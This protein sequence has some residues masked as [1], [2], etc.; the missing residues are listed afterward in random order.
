ML[1][2]LRTFA[3][4]FAPKNK[5]SIP[6]PSS[7]P[8]S[9]PSPSSKPD[10][11]PNINEYIKEWLAIENIATKRFGQK[12]LVNYPNDA[13]DPCEETVIDE[14]DDNKRYT[15]RKYVSNSTN[16]N[17]C[18]S[19]DRIKKFQAP[20]TIVGRYS[21]NSKTQYSI[22]FEMKE[23]VLFN[24]CF[25]IKGRTFPMYYHVMLSEETNNVYILFP[26]GGIFEKDEFNKNTELKE[27]LQE[28]VD[29]ILEQEMYKMKKII[30]CG[31]S[32][33]CVLAL[34]TGMIMQ[35]Q[36]KDFFDNNVIIIGSAPFKYANDESFT[37]LKNVMVFV[38]A[39]SRKGGNGWDLD[40]FVNQG[41]CEFNY[42]PITYVSNS[43]PEGDF[44][45]TIIN[46]SEGGYD[47][48]KFMT[49][50]GSFYHRWENYQHVL[51][52]IYVEPN[53][54]GHG[55]GK[56]NKTRRRQRRNK[57][58]NTKKNNTQY[59]KNTQYKNNKK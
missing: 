7:S 2:S 48:L 17:T 31:H 19:K 13:D 46:I 35:K 55:G 33:G 47:Y 40:S 50:E 8:S 44:D 5:S 27:F 6:Q 23:S 18:V 39:L 15:C 53:Y 58:R 45:S 4:R 43:T 1:Q 26:A 49:E 11:I 16:K 32:M 36:D 29:K 34:Y 59:K 28:L 22:K 24:N 14:C 38:F 20:N 10:M 21:I 52:E 30:I 42:K 51:Y 3:N 12:Y 56:L 37:N 57:K 41:P 9:S 25:V 54:G